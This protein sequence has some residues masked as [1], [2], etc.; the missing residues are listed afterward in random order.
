MGDPASKEKR[1]AC[2]EAVC[3]GVGRDESVLQAGT[4]RSRVVSARVGVTSDGA[5]HAPRLRVANGEDSKE[6][7]PPVKRR[8]KTHTASA[9]DSSP[10]VPWRWGSRTGNKRLQRTRSFT[11]G[12]LDRGTPGSLLMAFP[13]TGYQGV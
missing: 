7:G 12:Y 3:G 10:P 5:E 1:G 13:G 11:R 6:S 2:R 4:T 9:Q 8:G